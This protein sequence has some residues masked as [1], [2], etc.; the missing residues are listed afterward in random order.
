MKCNIKQLE[1]G[2]EYVFLR[3][4]VK[5]KQDIPIYHGTLVELDGGNCITALFHIHEFSDHEVFCYR[6]VNNPYIGDRSDEI[7]DKPVCF[8]LNSDKDEDLEN[9]MCRRGVGFIISDSVQSAINEYSE[10]INWSVEEYQKKIDKADEYDK[11][12]MI[13][14]LEAKKKIYKEQIDWL[15]KNNYHE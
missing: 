3:S 1:V 13:A 15:I 2:K 14:D 12:S 11:S 5:Q 10:F 8:Y 9:A 4:I 7:L 6:T